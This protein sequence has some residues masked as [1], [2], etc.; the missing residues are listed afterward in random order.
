MPVFLSHGKP[1]GQGYGVAL[2]MANRQEM[3]AGSSPL[4]W[5]SDLLVDLSDS[6]Q[7]T[8]LTDGFWTLCSMQRVG[9]TQLLPPNRTWA[10]HTSF[11]QVRKPTQMPTPWNS[12]ATISELAQLAR[13]LIHCPLAY[14]NSQF[15]NSLVILL[16][17][18]SRWQK[19]KTPGILQFASSHATKS[20]ENWT[21]CSWHSM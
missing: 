2:V 7:N 18:F 5:L 16:L 21:S 3:Q 1:S 6:L 11:L 4:C 17:Q 10:S 14:G 8:P 13:Y 20:E 9:I 12:R 15:T 19:G